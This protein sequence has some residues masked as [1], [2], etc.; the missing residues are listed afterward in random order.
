ML[1]TH[2]VQRKKVVEGKTSRDGLN[3]VHDPITDPQ[4]E[5][6]SWLTQ[7]FPL[8]AVQMCL[9]KSSDADEWRGVPTDSRQQLVLS[10]NFLSG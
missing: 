5:R 7:R 4:G 3:T 8:K 1:C 10:Q 2:E 9:L 6:K